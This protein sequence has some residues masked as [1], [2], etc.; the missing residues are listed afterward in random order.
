MSKRKKLTNRE[1]EGILREHHVKIL[2]LEN[3]IRELGYYTRCY[4]EF[5]KTDKRFDRY[6]KKRFEADKKLAQKEMEKRK[7]EVQRN[8]AADRK[9][10]ATDT[11]DKGRRTEGVRQNG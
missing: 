5:R 2:T 10:L 4:I 9:N 1:M 8:E 3:K 11:G 7:N 6:F